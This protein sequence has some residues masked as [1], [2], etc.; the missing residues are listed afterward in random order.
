MQRNL[1]RYSFS[2][3]IRIMSNNI[4][5]CDKTWRNRDKK[6]KSKKE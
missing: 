2:N 4:N 3:T 1:V 5:S 6:T